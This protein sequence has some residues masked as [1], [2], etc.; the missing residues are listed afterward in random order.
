MRLDKNVVIVAAL[1]FCLSCAGTAGSD[2]SS[3]TSSADSG[4]TTGATAETAEPEGLAFATTAVMSVFANLSGASS[5]NL[6]YAL[7]DPTQDVCGTSAPDPDGVESQGYGDAGTY[8]AVGYETTVTA[9]DYCTDASGTS[10]TGT[11]PDGDGLFRSFRVSIATA[12][13]AGGATHVYL[14]EGSGIFRNTSDHFPEIY[15]TFT[16]AGQDLDCT[17]KLNEDGTAD[18]AHCTDSSGVEV[19]AEG[20]GNCTLTPGVIAPEV[21]SY[22]GIWGPALFQ[23]AQ[24]TEDPAVLAEIGATFTSLVQS[25]TIDENGTIAVDMSDETI[26]DKILDYYDYGIGVL[27]SLDTMYVVSGADRS[28]GVPELPGAVAGSA[29]FQSNLNAEAVSLAAL[30]EIYDVLMFAPYNEPDLKM[31]AEGDYS[32]NWGQDVIDDVRAAYSG[33]VLWKAGLDVSGIDFTG[34]DAAG[35]SLSR[36]TTESETQYRARVVTTISNLNT[37]ATIA[38]VTTTMIS[39]FGVWGEAGDLLSGSDIAASYEIVF[40]EGEGLVDGFIAF[41]GPDGYDP[42]LY[43]GDGFAADGDAFD[44][45]KDWFVNRL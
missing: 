45:V 30:A 18:E 22:K 2:T 16:V 44:V 15:G 37:A 35:T 3:A 11:G 32:S 43:D 28:T 9:N 42:P 25:G 12:T 23:G 14:R 39:E 20:S 4:T 38:G 5:Q 1:Y 13:C 27:L 26:G 19:V 31:D 40:E 10:N 7:A 41:D 8:G 29:T 34:Y 33:R 24:S 17:I 6:K 36:G 21:T